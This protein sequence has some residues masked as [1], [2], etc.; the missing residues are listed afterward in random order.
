MKPKLL[1]L[2]PRFPYPVIG[3]DRLRIYQ[4]CRIL[5]Y[6]FELSL[7]SLT[8]SKCDTDYKKSDDIFSK[9]EV[10]YMPKWKSWLNCIMA[11]PTK[12]PLQVAYYKNPEFRRR[13]TLLS[14]EHDAMFAHLIR[15]GDAIKDIESVKFL[16]MT[17]AISLNYQRIREF[18]HKNTKFIS[19]VYSFEANRLRHCEEKI[20]DYFNLSILVSEVDRQYLFGNINERNKHVVVAGNGINLENFKYSYQDDAIDLIFIG[21]MHSFQNYDAALYMASEILPKIRRY[22]PNLQLRLIG[23]IAKRDADTLSV[24]DGVY[25]TDEVADVSIAALGGAIGVCPVRLGAG[26]QN[27]VL[28]YMALGLPVVTTSIGLQGF[29][30]VNGRHLVVADDANKFAYEILELLENKSKRKHMAEAARAY[31]EEGYSWESKLA[32]VIEVVKKE[33]RK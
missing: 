22:I 4:M 19:L 10:I 16:E 17:D 6:H 3:G 14:V 1:I 20:I 18:G 31:I 27:K 8:D 28:E 7:L 24:Y 5:S 13:A 32:S 25:V 33:I 30:A 9:I 26:V 29:D 2:T 12:I 23:R 11:I 15:V 21:N